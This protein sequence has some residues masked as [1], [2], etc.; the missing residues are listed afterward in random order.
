MKELDGVSSFVLVTK[1][2]H[3]SEMQLFSLTFFSVGYTADLYSEAPWIDFRDQQCRRSVHIYIY[4]F[5]FSPAVIV[6]GELAVYYFKH[7]VILAN[8]H[9]CKG[10]AHYNNRVGRQGSVRGWVRYF[11]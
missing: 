6:V 3:R 9:A 2:H 5:F 7:I 10:S 4:M 8:Y 1:R 11:H